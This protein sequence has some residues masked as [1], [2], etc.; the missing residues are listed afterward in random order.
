MGAG[1]GERVYERNLKPFSEL[2]LVQK[3]RV[4]EP[5][6]E[7]LA[8]ICQERGIESEQLLGYMLKRFVDLI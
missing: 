7:C 3:R 6:V 2:S 1:D 5:L 4:T 8:K